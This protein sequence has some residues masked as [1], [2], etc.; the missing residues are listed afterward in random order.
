VLNETICWIL[1]Q[2]GKI[3]IHFYRPDEVNG[4]RRGLAPAP[5]VSKPE[6]EKSTVDERPEKDDDSSSKEGS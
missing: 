4:G 3:A 6:T 1:I 2:I 5:L